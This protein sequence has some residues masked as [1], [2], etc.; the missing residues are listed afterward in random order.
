[1]NSFINN[2]NLGTSKNWKFL[3]DDLISI[4]AADDHRF[5]GEYNDKEIEELYDKMATEYLDGVTMSGF[6][7]YEDDIDDI[8]DILNAITLLFTTTAHPMCFNYGVVNGKIPHHKLS[9]EGMMTLH[10]PSLIV[11][12]T[13]HVS[14]DI[15]ELTKTLDKAMALYGYG[16]MDLVYEQ[17]LVYIQK[18]AYAT[19]V[20]ET[21][22][23]TDSISG[24]YTV[25]FED[26]DLRL[27]NIEDDKERCSAI[28]TSIFGDEAT[29]AYNCNTDPTFR[30]IFDKDKETLYTVYKEF[31]DEY[32]VIENEL[33]EE[34]KGIFVCKSRK[35]PWWSNPPKYLRNTK[36]IPCPVD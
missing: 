28:L 27:F 24:K 36:V 10:Y 17:R 35:L 3:R 6:C 30:L 19:L 16:H 18:V 33:V 12:D 25:K 5:M 15:T 7:L 13:S 14:S 22:D 1:M 20:K 2:D 31:I 32:N 34:E 21:T 26:Y 9:K 29:I 4:V 11:I 8:N 23:V